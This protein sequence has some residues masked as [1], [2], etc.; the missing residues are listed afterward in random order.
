MENIVFDDTWKEKNFNYEIVLE[1]LESYDEHIRDNIAQYCDHNDIIYFV[2][3]LESYNEDKSSMTELELVEV[4]VDYRKHLDCH[5][6]KN[7]T[8]KEMEYFFKREGI[9]YEKQGA[10]TFIENFFK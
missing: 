5:T 7:Y 8:E 10:Y 2:E 6:S 3:F 9:K 4:M 1:I